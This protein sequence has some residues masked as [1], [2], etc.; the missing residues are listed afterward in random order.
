[1]KKQNLSSFEI[2]AIGRVRSSLKSIAD[3]PRQGDEGGTEAWVDIEEGYFRALEGLKKEDW[4]ILL[5]FFHL[6]ER[7][8]LRV[9]PRN[10]KKNP[11]TGVFA[12]RSP[13][14]PNPI[15]LH[16]VI[17]KE[18][19]PTSIQV[20]PLEAIDATPIIDIKPVLAE[21]NDF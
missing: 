8:T 3:A 14:R 1:M 7:E 18:I 9:H 4:I 10:E 15:G 19:T 16:R 12:T 2:K 21:S 5:S 6:S 17:I 20:H 11:M 13:D